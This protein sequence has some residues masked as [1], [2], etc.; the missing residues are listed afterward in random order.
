MKLAHQKMIEEI[1]IYKNE[2]DKLKENV[3]ILTRQNQNITSEIDNIINEDDHLKDLLSRAERMTFSLKD[4]DSI[5]NQL[6][7]DIIRFINL[8]DKN[9]CC[10]YNEDKS[11]FSQIGMIKEKNFS[12]CSIFLVEQK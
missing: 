3:M 8:D 12:P 4:N 7:E 1:N 11:G 9:Y 5:L 2:N 6:P 10:V